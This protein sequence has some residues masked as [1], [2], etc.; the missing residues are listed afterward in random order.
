MVVSAT[1]FARAFGVGELVIGLTVVAVGTSLPEVAASLIAALHGE[2]DIAVGNAVGSNIFNIVTVLGLT[3]ILAP[4]GMEVARAV[5]AFDLP[6]MIAVAVACLPLFFTGQAVSRWEGAL[7]LAYYGVYMLYLVLAA[8]HHEL[9]PLFSGTVALYVIPLT[10]LTL[11]V[12]TWREARRRL[13]G[14]AVR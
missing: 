3:G 5:L 6:V 12:V 7:L 2:R 1:A 10:A 8:Q 13:R 14:N 4:G 9:L 11:A